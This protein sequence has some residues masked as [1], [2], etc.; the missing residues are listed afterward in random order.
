MFMH[1]CVYYLTGYKNFTDTYEKLYT[2]YKK[3]A[4]WI[5]FNFYQFSMPV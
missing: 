4:I 1:G 2:P 3:R 5:M